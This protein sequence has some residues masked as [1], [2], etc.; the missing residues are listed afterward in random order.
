MTWKQDQDA[1][2]D[3]Q[4]V[5]TEVM[6]IALKCHELTLGCCGCAEYQDCKVPVSLMP[7]LRGNA[8]LMREYKTNRAKLNP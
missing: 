2:G 4:S 1:R 6:E 7:Q 3:I 5:P 8:D